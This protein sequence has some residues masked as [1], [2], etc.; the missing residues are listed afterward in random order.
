MDRKKREREKGYLFVVGGPGGSGSSVISSMLAKHFSLTRIYAGNI[1]RQYIK[2]KGYDAFEDFYSNKNL[3][4]LLDIDEEVDRKLV[5]ESKKKNILIESKIFSGVAY[6]KDIPCTVKI[7]IDASL[8]T[9]ALRHLGKLNIESKLEK[10]VTYFRIRRNLR[11]RWELDKR[12]YKELYGIDYSNPK[13]YNDIVIDSSKMNEEQ[14]FNLILKLLAD[15][16]F[17]ERE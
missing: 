17:I 9:R 11:K 4:K 2:Q 13:V 10:I 15:G 6:V 16:R 1:F 3:N 8:H 7:W 12:R 5:E 14:T